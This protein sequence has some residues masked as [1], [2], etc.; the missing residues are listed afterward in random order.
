AADQVAEGDR[1]QGRPERQAERHRGQR[2]GHDR[3]RDQVGREPDGE[4]VP[5]AAVP[6][7]LGY[8][9]DR[10][11]LDLQR[12][13]VHLG[14]GRGGLGGCWACLLRHGYSRGRGRSRR[15]PA[16]RLWMVIR[17]QAIRPRI[18]TPTAAYTWV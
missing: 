4:Q 15:S 11:L 7:I 14:P 5:W 17:G 10:V 18:E 13:V 12:A 1:H 8:L 3:Q 9:R 16:A 6:L 2:A